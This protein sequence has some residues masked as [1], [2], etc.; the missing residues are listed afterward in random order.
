MIKMKKVF[1]KKGGQKHYLEVG[2]YRNNRLA[3]TICD[4]ND[5]Y[6]ADITINLPGFIIEDPSQVFLSSDLSNEQVDYLI[7]KEIIDRVYGPKQYNMGKYYAV[8]INLDVLKEYDK[9]G[10]ESFIKNHKD[11]Y[12]DYLEYDDNK[13]VNSNKER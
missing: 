4:G 8:S 9:D 10:V 11:Y 5:N 6:I 2:Q 3:I 13:N 7:D 12:N 1:D